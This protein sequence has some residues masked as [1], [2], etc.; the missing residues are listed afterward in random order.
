MNTASLHRKTTKKKFENDLDKKY[1][2]GV[3]HDVTYERNSDDEYAK[4]LIVHCYYEVLAQEPNY[5][6]R[7]CGTW[8]NGKAWEFVRPDVKPGDDA[9]I[10]CGSK[11]GDCCAEWDAEQEADQKASALNNAIRSL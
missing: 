10:F 11:D 4:P 5:R 9:C 3:T 2:G 6:D 8:M 7:H 1:P